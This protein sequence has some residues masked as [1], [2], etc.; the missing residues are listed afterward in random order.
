[1]ARTR[2]EDEQ[3]P[4]QPAAEIKIILRFFVSEK[5]EGSETTNLRLKKQ[6]WKR[7]RVKIF[8]HRSNQKEIWL[9]RAEIA[10]EGLNKCIPL[11]KTYPF[12]WVIAL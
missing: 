9:Q 5:D 4:K 12:L 1:M 2:Y 7:K 3:Q 10:G 6:F 8:C 11:A